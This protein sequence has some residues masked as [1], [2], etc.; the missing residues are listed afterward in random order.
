MNCP[1]QRALPLALALALAVGSFLPAEHVHE[2]DDH[3]ATVAHRHFSA[4]QHT[5]TEIGDPDE[6]VIWLDDAS[7]FATPTVRV[8]GVL[9]IFVGPFEKNIQPA[10]WI[11]A[12]SYDATPPHGPPKPI[13]VP[14]APPLPA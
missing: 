14:R 5:Q 9:G 6:R 12:P 3:H 1:R 2:G 8:T 7:L 4:H 11:P 10:D 13:L